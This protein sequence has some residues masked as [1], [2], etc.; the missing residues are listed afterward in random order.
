MKSPK[1]TIFGLLAAVG[2]YFATTGTGT[3]QIV[4]QVVT[5]LATFL[6]GS[7]AQDKIK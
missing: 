3:L 4:G 7:S 2:G 5:G 6:L 1:T